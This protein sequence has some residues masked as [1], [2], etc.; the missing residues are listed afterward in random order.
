MSAWKS[1]RPADGSGQEKGGARGE[2]PKPSGDSGGPEARRGVARIGPSITIRG[3]LQADEDLILEGRVD[4]H[5]EVAN[6]SLT[7]GA[8]T[9]HVQAELKAREVTVLGRVVGNVLAKERVE[10][11][12]TGRVD[13]AVVV[14]RLVIR[15]GAV[16]NGRITMGAPEQPAGERARVAPAARA[17]DVASR[18]APE[19]AL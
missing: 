5:V 3:D 9:H 18:R 7:I 10:I 11:A 12:S 4:G 8:D 19:T 17:P 6:H 14:P 1:W 13:G 2:R 15:E 16:V